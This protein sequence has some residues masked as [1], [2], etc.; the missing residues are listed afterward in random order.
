V[1]LTRLPVF[2]GTLDTYRIREP[3]DFALMY[4]FNWKN[5][6]IPICAICRVNSVP[7]S[8][9]AWVRICCKRYEQSSFMA[10]HR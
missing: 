8:S 2:D 3:E 4:R 1:A 6:D 10:L 9:T 5:Q 7:A